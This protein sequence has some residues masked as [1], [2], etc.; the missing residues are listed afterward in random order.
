MSGAKKDTS[1]FLKR[2]KKISPTDLFLL[3]DTDIPYVESFLSVA[4]SRAG[5][6]TQSFVNLVVFPPEAQR[7][8]KCSHSKHPVLSLW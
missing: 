8:K 4:R 6:K 3:L 1:T 7:K 2:K 5:G